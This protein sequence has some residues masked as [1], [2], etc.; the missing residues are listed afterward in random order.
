MSAYHRKYSSAEPTLDSNEFKGCNI[1]PD[2]QLEATPIY[3][4]V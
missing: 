3:H 2:R 1:S 4:T